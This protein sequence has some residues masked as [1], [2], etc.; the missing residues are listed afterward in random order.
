[1][2]GHKYHS[3]VTEECDPAYD[4]AKHVL[5]SIYFGNDILMVKTTV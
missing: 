5:K 4:K 3:R 1:M 2:D